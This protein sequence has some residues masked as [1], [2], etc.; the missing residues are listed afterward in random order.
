VRVVRKSERVLW[1]FSDER[2]WL[3]L[4]WPS[5]APLRARLRTM[6]EIRLAVLYGAAA[7][8][9]ATGDE[10]LELIVSVADDRR[11]YALARTL[12]EA[13]GR[14][15]RLCS[16]RQAREDHPEVL[17]EALA[18]A[19]PARSRARVGV[20]AAPAPRAPSRTGGGATWAHAQ[21]GA[22]A[23]TAMRSRRSGAHMRS[24]IRAPRA[25]R[26]SARAAG[27]E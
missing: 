18:S 13:C 8:T 22:R 14:E 11:L 19:R 25:P 23:M 12:R 9:G 3:L 24:A 1:L 17:V 2:R 4:I 7:H 6:P 10:P 21:A 26:T 5:L 15:V 20:A 16:L 27:G